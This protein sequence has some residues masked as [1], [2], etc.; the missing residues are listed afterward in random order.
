MLW[1][2]APLF[3]SE[4]TCSEMLKFE[5]EGTPV[6]EVI[7]IVR[8]RGVLAGDL[9]CIQAIGLPAELQAEI[10]KWARVPVANVPRAASSTVQPLPAVLVELSLPD[11][12]VATQLSAF[13]GFGAGHF[14]SCRADAGT[15]N[16]LIQ[17]A[18]VGLVSAGSV[19]AKES[20]GDAVGVTTVGWAVLGA[21]RLLDIATAPH[22]AEVTRRSI[23]V[24]G[25]AGCRK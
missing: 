10:E 11:P 23:L 7:A 6:A 5:K 18:G 1:L 16:L 8:E 21:G 13:V 24:N 14:Y 9:E 20:P 25:G 17:L 3:A 12:A 22:S 15:A 19:M 2:I 4:I